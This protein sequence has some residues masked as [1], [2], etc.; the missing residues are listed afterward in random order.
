M[1]FCPSNVAP[2]L[3]TF[4][5]FLFTAANFLILSYFD[6]NFQSNTDHEHTTPIPDVVWL[7]AVVN[8]FLAY[9]LDGI[10]GK[11]ARK[12]GLS[13]PL[14]ELFDHGLDSYTAVLI[15][16]CL[17]S[18][19][20][21]CSESISS[22]RMYLICWTV[23]LNFYVSHWEKYITGVLYLPWGYDISMWGSTGMYLISWWFGYGF[24][25]NHMLFGM[26]LGVV[27]ETVLHV[28]AMSNIPMVVIN[29]YK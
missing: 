6:W 7:I 1:Q 15:P 16:V 2:N 29:I 26:S 3:L 10:D 18:I 9:T 20:G 25:K 13:G 28:S 11:Q 21:N 22:M 17:Y 14:G 5:G 12:I 24:W 19:F 23:F 4:V 8:I 27:M